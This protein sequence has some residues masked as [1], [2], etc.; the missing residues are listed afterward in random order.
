MH[1]AA[2]SP[3]AWVVRWA[4]QVPCGG[5][6]L[7]VACGHGRHAR[8][9]AAHGHPVDAVD[10]NAEAL[11]ALTGV[12][13]IATCRADIESGAW[14]YAADTYACVVVTHYLHRPL[15]PRLLDALAPGGVLLYETFALGNERYGRPS[16]PDFLLKP[17]ELLDVVRGRLMVH[18]YEDILIEV[19]R[20][21]RLQRI[22]A[23]R[24]TNAA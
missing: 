23:W 10:R 14:P 8:W 9:F 1:A 5:R 2:D 19:P 22:C 13:N 20:P 15:F 7:D 4:R 6:V 16:N 17:G 24:A 11:A 21:A 18:A 12:P 3:S